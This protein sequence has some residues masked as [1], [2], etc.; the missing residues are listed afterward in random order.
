V[1]NGIPLEEGKPGITLKLR[2]VNIRE[3]KQPSFVARRQQHH[4]MTI[5]TKLVFNPQN[6]QE[7]QGL[8]FFKTKLTISL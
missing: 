8:Y 7:L 5:E 4:N 3:L 1:K 2:D 6:A